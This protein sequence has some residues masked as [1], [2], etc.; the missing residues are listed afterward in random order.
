MKQFDVPRTPVP[1]RRARAALTAAALVLVGGGICFLTCAWP[2]ENWGLLIPARSPYD[3]AD[4][5]PVQQPPA[6]SAAAVRL[7]DDAEVI[8]VAAGGRHRAYALDAFVYWTKRHVVNDVVGGVPITVTHCDLTEC[9]RVFT[10]PDRDGPLDVSVGGWGGRFEESGLLLRVGS[11]RYRQT[12]GEPLKDGDPPFPYAPAEY[13]RTTWKRW[14][15]AH[16]DTDVYV[17]E[18]PVTPADA[19]PD[20]DKR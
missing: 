5:P 2:T 8:G 1:R 16:P 20:K 9:T 4:L 13:V 19:P 14:R 15:E 18:L 6:L 3:L 7:A 10:A 11:T 12:T 17:G